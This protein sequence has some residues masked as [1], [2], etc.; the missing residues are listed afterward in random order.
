MLA[1]ILLTAQ[2]VRLTKR[3]LAFRP[4]EA[5]LYPAPHPESEYLLYIH[6]PFCEELCPFCSFVRVKFEAS[7]A[8]DYFASLKKEIQACCDSGFRFSAVYIGGGTPTIWPEKLAEVV[9][10]TRRLWPI[11]QLSVETNPNHL[12][13]NALSVL[14]DIGT[15]RLSVGVQSFDDAILEDVRRRHKYGS[16]DT[17]RDRVAA[18]IGKF[19][20]VNIDMIFNLPG[21]DEAKLAGD[22]K[23]AAELAADQV[24]WY[25]LMLSET[26]KRQLGGTAEVDFARERRMYEMIVDGLAEAYRQE[27]IWCFSKKA[28]LIDEYPVSHEEYIGTGPG[29]LSYINGSLYVNAFSIPDYMNRVA[30]EGFSPAMVRTFT[31]AAQMRF[32]MALRLLGGKM[33]IGAMQARH[34]RFWR[35]VWPEMLFLLSTRAATVRNGHV[36]LT[37]KGRYYWLVIMR[38][39]F[40]S[41]GEYRDKHLT[42]EAPGRTAQTALF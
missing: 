12:A 2:A 36:V 24:T 29:A 8:S 20:T 16:A 34:G 9:D 27:S 21:Q 37:R 4:A 42:R 31:R 35:T 11:R 39:L 13:G 6:I 22:I 33:D 7:A 18:V 23:S 38:T 28:G 30:Q 1:E 41:L 26:K 32:D 17:I 14:G 19:D 3:Y 40:S 15:N 10:L 5:G 25:P